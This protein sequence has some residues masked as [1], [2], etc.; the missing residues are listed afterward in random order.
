[1]G[2]F[3]KIW[4]YTGTVYGTEISTTSNTWLRPSQAASSEVLENMCDGSFSGDGAVVDVWPSFQQRYSASIYSK[5]NAV[6]KIAHPIPNTTSVFANAVAFVFS[7]KQ[8]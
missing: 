5:V 4:N 6:I 2:N 3:N 1:M 8:G 7:A